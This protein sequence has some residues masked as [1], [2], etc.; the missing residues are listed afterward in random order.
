MPNTASV[1]PPGLVIVI[2]LL[3]TVQTVGYGLPPL[4]G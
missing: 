4:Q 1:T 3:P 2:R